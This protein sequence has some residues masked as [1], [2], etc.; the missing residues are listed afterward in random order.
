[1]EHAP[2]HWGVVLDIKAIHLDDG[3]YVLYYPEASE[4]SGEFGASDRVHAIDQNVV[5]MVVDKSKEEVAIALLA[6][7]KAKERDFLVGG[8]PNDEELDR[9]VGG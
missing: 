9:K 7:W 1:M 6:E 4:Q 3:S 2:L 8:R 5:V